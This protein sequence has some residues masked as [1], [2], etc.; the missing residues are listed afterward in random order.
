MLLVSPSFPI[1]IIIFIFSWSIKSDA[2]LDSFM[3]IINVSPAVLHGRWPSS[4]YTWDKEL[5]TPDTEDDDQPPRW[6][7]RLVPTL[8]PGLLRLP[9][10][11]CGTC[12]L[13]S[14][15]LPFSRCLCLS[16]LEANRL[17]LF[18]LFSI[19]KHLFTTPGL[20][21]STY[22]FLLPYCHFSGIWEQGRNKCAKST[23]FKGSQ[24]NSKPL[25]YCFYI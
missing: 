22:R 5:T 7:S 24:L 25:F 17:A 6:L 3:Q 21:P 12:Q 15:G 19:T 16:P 1:R 23:T 9:R 20:C 18:H 14:W 11:R 8:V 13:A 10:D 4:W 2:S